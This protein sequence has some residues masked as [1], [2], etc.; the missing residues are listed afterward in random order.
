MFRGENFL[1]NDPNFGWDGNFNEV[2][3]NPAVFVYYAI[4]EL[5][6]GDVILLKGDIT[7][8]R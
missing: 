1:P 6:D 3:M 2:P 5:V 7:L 4:V 8:V